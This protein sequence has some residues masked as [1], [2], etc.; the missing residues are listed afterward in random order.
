MVKSGL[1]MR[2]NIV[3]NGVESRDTKDF[4]TVCYPRVGNTEAD[5][6]EIFVYLLFDA[7]HPATT[8]HDA[9]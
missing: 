3:R 6:T 5:S 2:G 9:L 4:G 8:T 7:S 1:R